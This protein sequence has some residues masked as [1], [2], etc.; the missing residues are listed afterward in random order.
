[1]AARVD[2]YHA[3]AAELSWLRRIAKVVMRRQHGVRSVRDD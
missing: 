3:V 2:T 1:M